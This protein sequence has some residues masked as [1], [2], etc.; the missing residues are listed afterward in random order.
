MD[1]LD[2]MDTKDIVATSGRK[3]EP[4]TPSI[5]GRKA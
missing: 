5:T 1:T 4:N 3:E 2:T